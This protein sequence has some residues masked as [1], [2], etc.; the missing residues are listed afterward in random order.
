MDKA[1]ELHLI[2][3]ERALE[4]LPEIKPWFEEK[5][6]VTTSFKEAIKVRE[7]SIKNCISIINER[8]KSA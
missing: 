3:Y 1:D 4:K 2:E 8:A 7:A 5:Q 6:G